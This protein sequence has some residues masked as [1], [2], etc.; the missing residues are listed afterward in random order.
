MIPVSNPRAGYLAHKEEID[1]AIHAA[2][3]SGQYVMGA[4]VEAFEQEFATYTQSRHAIGVASGTDAIEMILRAL[5]I[6]PGDEVITVAQTATG[7]VAPIAMVGASPV[8]VGVERETM[9]MNPVGIERAITAK[10]AA[11]MPVH[12]FGRACDIA[13]IEAIADDHGLYLIEDACQAHGAMALGWKVGGFGIAGAFSHYPTKNLNCLGDGGSIVTDDDELADKLRHMRFYGWDDS[14]N[15]SVVCGQSRLDTIQAAVLSVKLKY[16]DKENQRR[17]DIA[18]VYSEVF[19][20]LED[21]GKCGAGYYS[22]D[23]DS[24][25][26]VFHQYVIFVS[27]RGEIRAALAENGISTSIHYPVAVE[28]QFAYTKYTSHTGREPWLINKWIMSLP[29][30]PELTDSEVEHVAESLRDVFWKE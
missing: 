16:L 17:R 23:Y 2:V 1:E 10:T 15:T 25:G 21:S 20:D 11:I 28:N 30:Y 18:R 3:D 14:K 24:L 8:F 19:E 26:N 9:C 13:T 29:M 6:G 4:A 5:G 12:L 22:T 27:N 7:T